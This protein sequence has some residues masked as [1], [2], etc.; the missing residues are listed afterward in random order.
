MIPNLTTSR[1]LSPHR[2][3]GAA[4]M[5][6]LWVIAI[7]SMAVFTATQ[8]LMVSLLNDSNDSSIFRAEQ[9]AD[10]G[11]AIGSHPDIARGDPLLLREI[12]EVESY[13]TRISSEG[14]RLNLNSLLEFPEADRIVLEELFAMVRG[15]HHEGVLREAELF[16]G[17]KH[18]SHLRVDP[19][20]AAVI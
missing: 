11:I 10:R 18:T 5:A 14:D 17:V 16:E 7:L 2:S 13:Q 4:L 3:R 15:D 6:I 1:K 19:R 12:N 9:L 8:L 20:D